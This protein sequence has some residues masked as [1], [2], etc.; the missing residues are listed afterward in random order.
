M[1]NKGPHGGYHLGCYEKMYDLDGPNN[2]FRVSADGLTLEYETYVPHDMDQMRIITGSSVH[3]P[4]PATMPLFG[5]GLLG[6]A[7]IGRRKD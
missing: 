6:L 5:F 2:W 4:E 1:G 7:G 3:A